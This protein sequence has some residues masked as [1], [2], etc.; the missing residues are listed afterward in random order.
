MPSYFTSSTD[1]DAIAATLPAALLPFY[2]AADSDAKTTALELAS[3]HVDQAYRW[4][5]RK[6]ADYNLSDAPQ[7]LEFPRVAYESDRQGVHNR[8]G[9]Y[10]INASWIPDMIW[11]W[12]E[13]NMVPVVPEHI[14]RAVVFEAD[15]ILGGRRT[16]RQDAI[17]D[18]VAAQSIGGASESYRDGEAPALCREADRLVQKYRLKQGKLL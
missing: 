4:Q 12:D 17:H 8:V 10:D 5:G 2:N 7:P 15:S 1:S 3:W 16:N 13:V 18:G 14:L 11:D 9:A 6:Y